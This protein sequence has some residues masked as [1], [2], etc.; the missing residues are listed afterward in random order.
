MSEHDEWEDTPEITALVRALR[1]P[2]SPAELAGEDAALAAFRTVRRRRG[3]LVRRLGTGGTAVVAVVA[4]S[5]GVAAAAAYTNSLPQPMQRLAHTT[6]GKVGV[7]APP[8]VAPET[9]A[10]RTT[11]RPSASSSSSPTSPP[12]SSA[13][14][15]RG[16]ERS[17]SKAPT[18]V[19]TP[20]PAASAVLPV[21]PD[22]SPTTATTTDPTDSPSG[23]PSGAPTTSPTGSPTP[24]PTSSPTGSTAPKPLPKAVSIT[25]SAQ[26][27]DE[28]SSAMVTGVVTDE[29]GGVPARR[30]VVLLART[31]GETPWRPVARGRA[32]ASGSVT[33]LSPGLIDTT[34]LR[35]RASGARSAVVRVA[36]VPSLSASY[37]D[38]RIVVSTSAARAG[39]TVLIGARSGPVTTATL[40]AGGQASLAVE[41]GPLRTFYTVRLPASPRHAAA[42]LS[43]VVPRGTPPT[44][45]ST[46]PA[47][48][49][50]SG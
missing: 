24:S 21:S 36:V 31:A 14:A 50:G 15:T 20:T 1:A 45:P 25:L 39:E 29:A 47:P 46:T 9:A 12:D 48:S 37:A 4:L 13:P 49:T 44:A 19:L 43:V 5:G 8:H 10:A 30:V 38:G 26:R 2:G 3:G 17:P 28:G 33:L 34:R 41:A 22:G 32:D 40:G 11:G 23:M 35:L 16:D 42:Q 6:L 18:S 7:P 27:V